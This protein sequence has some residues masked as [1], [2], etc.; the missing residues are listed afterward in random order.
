MAKRKYDRLYSKKD[1]NSEKTVEIFAQDKAYIVVCRKKLVKLLNIWPQ[2]GYNFKKHCA[3]FYMQ[4]G[5]AFREC[6]KWNNFFNTDAFQV[7]EISLEAEG[8]LVS[9][10]V[11]FEKINKTIIRRKKFQPDI[12][13]KIYKRSN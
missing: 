7:L 13:K 11:T 8:Q 10:P 12:H 4:Q 5:S 6:D 1:P 9:R 3:F 2:M